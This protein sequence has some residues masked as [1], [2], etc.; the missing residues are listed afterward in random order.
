MT[1]AI[2]HCDFMPNEGCQIEGFQ[3]HTNNEL[4]WTLVFY[5]EATEQDLEDCNYLDEE[6]DY[7]W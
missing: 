4:E 5:H 1:S 7:V 2:H 6:G 3:S